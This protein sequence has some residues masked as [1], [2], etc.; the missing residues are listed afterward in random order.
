MHRKRNSLLFVWKLL[1]VAALALGGL[2]V[3]AGC[4][5]EEE[6]SFSDAFN[7]LGDAFSDWVDQVF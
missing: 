1:A 2:S 6:T 4:D 5:E 7:S 3:I